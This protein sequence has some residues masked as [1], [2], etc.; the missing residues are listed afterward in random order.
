MGEF[1]VVATNKS[2]IFVKQTIS[3][4]AGLFA[5]VASQRKINGTWGFRQCLLI[6][7]DFLVDV[8]RGMTKSVM[9]RH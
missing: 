8:M 6:S 7:D 3:S 1:R 9:V 5:K 2:T 4:A